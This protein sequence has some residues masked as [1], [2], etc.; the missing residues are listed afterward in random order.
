MFGRPSIE[1]NVAITDGVVQYWYEIMPHA[2]LYNADSALKAA[3]DAA[4]LL[5]GALN[6]DFS[7]YVV[8]YRINTEACIEFEKQLFREYGKPFMKDDFIHHYL[9]GVEHELSKTSYRYS[10]HLCLLDGQPS[11][12]RLSMLRDYTMKKTETKYLMKIAQKMNVGI[13][14]I[15]ERNQQ[16]SR[17]M[18]P[19]EII[20]V[21]EHLKNPE[22]NPA[23]RLNQ[24]TFI[25]TDRHLEMHGVRDG[26]EDTMYMQYSIV[27]KL[28]DVIRP[29]RFVS[30]IQELDFPITMIIKVEFEPARKSERK[31]IA[32]QKEIAGNIKHEK[33]EYDNDSIEQYTAL[34]QA[35]LA[36]QI[37]SLGD[38]AMA[39][40]QIMFRVYGENK[41]V[42]TK[43]TDDIASLLRGHGIT[44]DYML[45]KQRRLYIHSFPER[46]SHTGHIHELTL[47]AFSNLNV[48]SGYMVGDTIGSYF[49]YV[50]SDGTP[51]FFDKIRLLEYKTK[52]KSTTRII[53]AATRSGKTFF[54]NVD[55]LR[56]MFVYGQRSLIIEP[57]P[58][59]RRDAFAELP[60]YIS[61]YITFFDVTGKSAKGWFDPVYQNSY[62]R[63]I[64][65][66]KTMNDFQVL[67]AAIKKTLPSLNEA[68][69]FFTAMFDAYE[70]NQ[71]MR[72]IET[73][74]G[75]QQVPIKRLTFGVYLEII[76]NSSRNEQ[77]VAAAKDMLSLSK[78]NLGHLF[79][80]D[81]ETTI[82]FADEKMIY[83]ADISGL[84]SITVFDH[85]DLD[86]VFASLIYRKIDI[87]AEQF[88]IMDQSI[89]QITVEEY[90]RYKSVPGGAESVRNINRVAAGFKTFLDV[91]S[92]NLRDFD[93][94]DEKGIFNNTGQFLIGTVETK[95]EIDF[96]VETLR[97][98][99]T[100]ASELDF[101]MVDKSNDER[102]KHV[103]FW[104]SADLNIVK[105][106]QHAL[107]SRISS[108]MDSRG[109]EK[110][111]TCIDIT[112]Q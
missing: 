52:R 62:N 26:I 91:V 79:F 16:G 14:E 111:E 39:R 60:D 25:P 104:Q 75:R 34:N 54:L 8:P 7:L 57:K 50:A 45:G 13:A 68:E 41:E 46:N 30:R 36:E 100:I 89:K 33:R 99:P 61:K 55:M 106:K 87:L 42:V 76:I 53:V 6:M 51:I 95:D 38:D 20:R 64:A 59:E 84:P 28:P 88:M 107:D 15:I 3:S 17:M 48:L 69:G 31:A 93:T 85:N 29:Q 73:E 43:R 19:D 37:F 58:K 101:N 24:L 81:D 18:D 9:P 82:Q 66:T 72:I 11:M 2:T 4:R 44:L 65:L 108:A 23:K 56:C 98:S 32:K 40:T 92:Q 70:S 78:M 112:D 35:K 77:L 67:L 47:E 12:Q 110:N 74:S 94:E 102:K 97:L 90:V 27:D 105:M 103:F 63:E 22:I 71:L 10:I 1:R 83:V 80:A 96:I 109:A 5:Y 21:I 86:H 49:G